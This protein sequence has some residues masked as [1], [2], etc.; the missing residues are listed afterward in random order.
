MTKKLDVYSIQIV[1]QY[2]KT[3][4]DFLNIIQ[5]KKQFQY[6]LDRFRINPIPITN[7]TKKL[8]QYLRNFL[9]IV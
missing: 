5:V 4:E 8:F 9:E 1:S 3:K 2:L 7:E 6:V